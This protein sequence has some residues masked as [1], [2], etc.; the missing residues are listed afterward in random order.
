MASE[1][2]LNE[3]HLR[4]ILK[5]IFNLPLDEVIVF[6]STVSINIKKKKEKKGLYHKD[7]CPCSV[8]FIKQKD[9]EIK[10]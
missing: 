8:I 10:V 7:L 6:Y 2:C 5:M 4:M 3:T 1:C 9:P